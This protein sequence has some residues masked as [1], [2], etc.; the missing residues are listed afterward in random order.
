MDFRKYFLL[1]DNS[2]PPPAGAMTINVVV[3]LIIFAGIIVRGLFSLDYELQWVTIYN[4]RNIFIK[5]F[6]TTIILSIAS[7]LF[8]T[9]IG[10][11][12]G[13]LG[14]SRIITL[15]A[16]SRVYVE[17]IRGTPLIVQILIFFYVVANFLGLNNR[18]IAGVI[19]MSLFSGAYIAE[20]IRAG[21]E[22]I[23]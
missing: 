4:Y 12:F 14:R 16:L 3:L 20:I 11:V 2:T 23:G 8:S 17:I 6:Y 21:V 19:I 1:K 7:L 9:T 18:Y 10:V 13:L 22:S 5:G 15:R